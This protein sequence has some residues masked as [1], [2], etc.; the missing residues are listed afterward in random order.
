VDRGCRSG[1]GFHHCHYTRS[2]TF[3][4][5]LPFQAL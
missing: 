2:S 3:N 5:A 4:S 1:P